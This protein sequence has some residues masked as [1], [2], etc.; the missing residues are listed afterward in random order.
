MALNDMGIYPTKEEMYILFKKLDKDNDGLLR[1]TEFT[2]NILPEDVSYAKIMNSRSPL[3]NTAESGI[4]AFEFDTRYTFKKL[5]NKIIQGEMEAET[6]RQKLSKRPM[7]SI[8]DAFNALDT[9]DNGFITR[10]QFK[11][12]LNEHGMFVAQQDL[13][14]LVNRFDKDQD[15]KVSYKE[16]VQEM[17]PQS[18]YKSEVY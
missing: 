10:A 15:G 7:F 5:I 6:V 18:P 2:Q 1:Y 17:T 11:Q 14:Q 4:Y 9:E 12:I 16:F 8:N 3:Y 13:E